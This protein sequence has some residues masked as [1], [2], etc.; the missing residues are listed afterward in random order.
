MKPEQ[1]E[2]VIDSLKRSGR[3]IAMVGDGVNDVRA[4][5]AANVGI[6]LHSG[7]GA[8]RG[9]ADMVLVNDRFSAL[10]KAIIEG[11]RTVTGM[12]D[13]LRLYLTRNYGL[14][15]LVAVL[16]LALGRFPM[17]PV[18]NAFYALASVSFAAFLMAIWAKP[19]NNDTMILPGVL[20]FSI[21]MAVMIAGFGLA[22][23]V[24]FN[25]CTLNGIFELGQNFY[26][27]M[28]SQYGSSYG[29]FVTFWE[30]MSPNS[31]TFEEVTARNA[32]LIF[33]LF[34]GIA[35]LFFIYPLARFYSVD[36]VVSRD[37]KP[38]ILALLLFGLVVLVYQVPLVAVEVASLAI[39]PMEYFLLI[40]GIVVIWFFFAVLLLKSRLM[41][42]ISDASESSYKRSLEAEKEKE[43]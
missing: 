13:I 21:P 4:I 33:I 34:A 5:K 2:L 37:L 25:Y 14:A 38:T 35:Q 42:K 10:P 7:S 3:Y 6:A 9:V 28:F 41:R 22:V 23:Y 40:L 20:R 32:R 15:I 39:F 8:A 11:K 18:H 1:K 27:S 17:L 36:G 26:D 16:L 29:D 30:H 24:L 12:R 43:E 31:E 19:S